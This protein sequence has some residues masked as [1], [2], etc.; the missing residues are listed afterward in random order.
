MNDSAC[1]QSVCA[2]QQ[3]LLE[4]GKTWADY[5]ASCPDTDTDCNVVVDLQGLGWGMQYR[6]V[7]FHFPP[8][9][10]TGGG[11]DVDWTVVIAVDVHEFAPAYVV[12]YLVVL[13]ILAFVLILI[14]IAAAIILVISLTRPLRRIAEQLNAV[15]Q[16]KL[17]TRHRDKRGHHQI[18]SVGTHTDL[19]S[20]TGAS[21]TASSGGA[22]TS[23]QRG[24]AQGEG[25]QR[26]NWLGRFVRR[27]ADIRRRR[28]V[29]AHCACC[30]RRGRET[31]TVFAA[32]D[33]LVRYDRL[34]Q[35]HVGHRPPEL[36][37]DVGH[38]QQQ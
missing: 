22:G 38:I 1:Y 12:D 27:T 26:G 31:S 3:T 29:G 34:R 24:S 33:G 23:M 9:I 5:P 2:A 10:S 6:L 28:G 21:V 14:A 16:L 36:R 25:Q 15:A 32:A 37:D 20:L 18:R 4:G 13:P 19:L 30:I 17:A 8:N 35:R 11:Y 7:R